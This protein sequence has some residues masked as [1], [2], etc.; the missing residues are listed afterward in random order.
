MSLLRRAYLGLALLGAGLG[1]WAWIDGA[2]AGWLWAPDRL[3]LLAVLALWILAETLVRRNWSALWA[4]PAGVCFGPA[5]GVP[6]YLFLR[7]R[8]V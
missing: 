6:L 2:G 1:L 4:L 3:A 7:T 5:C 8:P